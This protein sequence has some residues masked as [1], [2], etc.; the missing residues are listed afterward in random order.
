MK[1]EFS[2]IETSVST[3]PQSFAAYSKLRVPG[4]I[5]KKIGWRKLSGTS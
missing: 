1:R 2:K 5:R 4:L 3:T